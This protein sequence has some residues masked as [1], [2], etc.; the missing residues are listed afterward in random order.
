MSHFTRVRTRLK[1]KAYIIAALQ[2][3]GYQVH[4]QRGSVRGFGNKQV[5][6]E[7]S[8]RPR[9]MSYAIGFRKTGEGYDIIADWWG[10]RGVRQAEFTRKLTQLYA[11]QAAK[12]NLEAQGF[13]LAEEQVDAEGR[14]HLLL[15]RMV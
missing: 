2:Q 6:V 9:P 14:I 4:D 8:V 12:Q 5:E 3:M 13:T 7:F 1:E 11:Y 10:V 15:R